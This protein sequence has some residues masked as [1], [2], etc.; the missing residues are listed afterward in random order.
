MRNT[1]TNLEKLEFSADRYLG[2]T[3]PM[4]EI[5]IWQEIEGGSNMATENEKLKVIARSV[6]GSF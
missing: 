4:D 5:N 2:I 6:L 1:G 3:E